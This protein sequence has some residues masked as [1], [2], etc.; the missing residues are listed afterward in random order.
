M[1]HV[2][3][4]RAATALM[5][6]GLVASC[7]VHG[8]PVP[9]GTSGP[10]T[11][12]STVVPRSSALST[13]ARTRSFTVRPSPPTLLD[14]N[15][16]PI[17]LG[18]VLRLANVQNPQLMIA[19]QR[20]VEAEALRQL[21]AVQ[22][23]PSINL[24]MNYDTHTGTLQQ[25]NGNIL[26]VNRSALYVGAG[27]GAVA[28]GTVDVP[29][30]VLS[31]NVAEGVFRYL[32]ARQV[33]AQR[34]FGTLAQRNQSFLA[35]ALAYC[36]LLRAEGH[37]AIALQ[38]REEARRVA[39][40]TG[41]YA[42]AGQG[43]QADAHRARTELDQREADVQGAE[44]EILAASARLCFVLN[45]DPSI[46]LHPTDAWVV[47]QPIVPGPMPLSE[48][49]AIAL[50]R[51]PELGERRAVIREAFLALE[52]S[53]VLPFSPT[54]LV[55]F[56][57][58]GFGGGSNLVRP[59]FGGFGG[60][61]DLDVAA[62]WT[63]LN[64]GVGNASLINLAKAHLGVTRLQEI[65]VMDQV[66]AEVAE[67]Y[68]R[69]HARFAQIAVTENAVRS[70]T[71]GFREDLIRIENTI[72]PALETVDSLRLLARSRYAYLD[73]IVDYNRAQFELYVGMGQPPAD[74]L[75]H[76][77]PNEGVTPT[78]LPATLSPD[79]TLA[80]APNEAPMPAPPGT[81]P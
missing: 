2:G 6:A 37:R 20:V 42:E 63:I 68:A 34:Q 54:V 56:S 11:T 78:D 29:G 38:V 9:P 1:S 59:I 77:V 39:E 25:S 58:G 17:D 60:R 45:L 23:L 36:E 5:V 62:Y 35:A 75:A 41:A 48:Q 55:G 26:S 14:P 28:A 3:L 15:V 52:G 46:R 33:V 31:G 4:T 44:G 80:P 72:A 40:L 32:T 22:I 53:R 19:R 10:R 79:R 71:R 81:S 49:I 64:L 70:G 7:P 12:D 61:S 65:A 51:R 47:P 67:A 30:V 57:S 27:S 16:R 50:L 66:R 18:T 21:A 13:A 8:Q 43:R 76:P 24:G 74:A 69:V 73:S